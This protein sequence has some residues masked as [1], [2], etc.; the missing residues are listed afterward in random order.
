MSTKQVDLSD[1]LK[2]RDALELATEYF[3]HR[4]RMNNAIHKGKEVR[5]S[6]I[7]SEVSAAN[8]R[9]KTMIGD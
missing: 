8:D 5:F 9:V 6:P 2:V 1:L 7:T 4:D 3:E